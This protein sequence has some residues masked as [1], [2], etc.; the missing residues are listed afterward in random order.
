MRDKTIIKPFEAQNIKIY[1][2]TLPQSPIHNGCI[3][4]G[5]T[6]RKVKDRVNEQ[7]KTIGL[8]ANIL[9]E[10]RA[11]KIDGTWFHDKDLHRYFIQNGIDKKD[12]G[13][14]ATE[15][16]YFNGTPEKAE[17]L[18][19]EFINIYDNKT[20]SI[21]K[22]EYKLRKEQ[23]LA[24]EK[25]L[26][27]F[28]SNEYKKEFLW[29]CK[30]RFGK[31][32][33]TYDFILK[34]NVN[35]VLLVTNRPTISNSWYDDFNKFIAWKY[36]NIKFV[37]DAK[38]LKNERGILSRK[39]Y[40]DICLV[41]EDENYKMVY[42]I[43]L[44][45]L[46]GAEEFGGNYDK[47]SWIADLPWDILVIDEAHEGVDTERTDKAFSKIKRD[48][49]LHLSGTPFKAIA[50]EKFKE[51]QIYNWSYIDEQKAKENWNKEDKN[52]YEDLPTLNLFTYQ[53][54]SL[55]I[56]EIG[57]ESKDLDID[58]T[59]DLNEFFRVENSEFVHKKEVKKF[60]DN[61]ATNKFPF[62]ISEHR[63]E[64][65]HTFWLLNRID[66]V[67]ALEKLLKQHSLF[68]NYKIISVAGNGKDNDNEKI[69]N[70]ERI[71]EA[72]KHNDRTITLSVGQLTTGV[73]IP[74]WTGVLMLSNIT[75][76]A[77]YFQTAFRVQNPYEYFDEDKKILMR[78]ENA[79]VFDFAPERTLT[80]FDEFANNLKSNGQKIN[81]ED[82]KENIKELLN[83][84]PVIA[85][86]DA[87]TLKE[88]NVE[89]ILTIPIK[90]KSEEI[91]RKGFMCNLLFDNVSNIFSV[92][93][94]LKTILDKIAPQKEG[95][96]TQIEIKDVMLD[97][98]NNV[99]ISRD[100][101][102]NTS[103]NIFGEKLYSNNLD[104]LDFDN[105]NSVKSVFK[106][107]ITELCDTIKEK[108]DIK[109]K[110]AKELETNF[111]NNIEKKIEEII[112]EY[113]NANEE[114]K[115]SIKIELVNQIQ[116]DIK[117][118]VYTI[119]QQQLELEE[120]TKKKTTEDE[121][122][123]HLRGFARTIPAF[124]MAYGNENTTLKNFEENISEDVFLEVT[125]ITIDE[126][127]KLR[128]GF[129]KKQEDGTEKYISGLF[130][131]NVFN[132]SIKK[133]F[134]VKSRL[135]NYFTN[136]SKEDIFD[137][138]PPQKTNQIFTPRNVVNTM[139]DSLEENE[140]NI[141]KDKNRKFLD[142]YVKSGL[143][144][145][146]IA[147]RLFKG[148]R[149]QIKNDEERIKWIF[150]NQLYGFAPSN[151]VYNITKNFIFGEFENIDSKNLKELDLVPA[152]KT[153][154][155]KEKIAEIWGENMKFDVII[156]NPPYQEMDGGAQSSAKPL[157]HFFVEEAQKINT[158]YISF[159]TPS[160]W[161]VGG[162]GLDKF[163]DNMLNC[164]NLIFICDCLTPEDIFPNTNIRG[165][166]CYFLMDKEVNNNNSIRLK[167]IKNGNIISNTKRPLKIDD[168][169]IFIRDNISIDILNKLGKFESLMHHISSRKPFGL[170]GNFT[171]SK[172]YY[173]DNNN[174]IEPILCY[175]K[176]KTIGY[177]EKSLI[178]NNT[179]WID[180]Y[181]VFTSY[182]NN[183]GTELSDDNLNAFVG[184][185]NTICTETYIV[186]GA[187]LNLNNELSMNLCKYLTTKFAR[188]LHSISKASQ[189]ATAK[190]YRFVPIQDF[191]NNSDIDWNKSIDEIDEQLFK[192]YG[193]DE[194]EINYIKQNIK[195]MQ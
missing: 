161:F 10:R 68:S 127:K 150:E 148:L 2:Y 84:F 54:S 11:Q 23:E 177:V 38:I 131:E 20:E 183:I 35:K 48:F 3:K 28:N 154:D 185:P 34:S 118:E 152:V 25:T 142:L 133:F 138:I 112:P 65:K 76:P 193:L 72:I 6:T 123:A 81:T 105:E 17:K 120:E 91:V 146:E 74:E 86:D 143:Y 149:E 102:I 186:I 179:L 155:L 101:V 187:D 70:L 141:F 26:E 22:I 5:E 163:R 137:Y 15:W 124:L 90:I 19:D 16:F 85:R 166:V 184:E 83:F 66:S 100:I 125:N 4:I 49:T 18:T 103:N 157:Y 128:D 126:F 140:P 165:G 115:E 113:K 158:K 109:N 43:S 117:Q 170:E 8:I 78:K 60:L 71:K 32:L 134:E 180:N 97:D 168:L 153:G 13:T 21:E 159:I 45:D 173:K 194:E 191:T 27:Y 178:K 106:E 77:L 36:K 82:R 98:E 93:N 189:H 135:S 30:P 94:E 174:L 50:N 52:P 114:E 195:P 42:F 57:K 75:S 73:T 151:I 121:V 130:D 46:K 181:K 190:T 67:N 136:E 61:L 56:E 69:T 111:K 24:V 104:E 167:T 116:E 119:V 122:R 172:E 147:K 145:T 182:T 64:L 160:R 29:N 47:Y 59:F 99:E 41:S 37:S 62:S 164:K 176:G 1:A 40:L 89:E 51:N 87:G 14:G 192:K 31:T 169:D 39:E 110:K 144:L 63:E 139:L 12:F 95:K 171:E 92:S 162:K 7:V 9:F 107:E 53:M 156:G 129:I 79:Y 80:L 188:F 88:L 175:G 58:F 33:T 108:F 132:S 44:Q 96:Y 55:I